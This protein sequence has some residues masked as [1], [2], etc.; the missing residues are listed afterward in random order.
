MGDNNVCTVA[1]KK[2]LRAIGHR[3]AGLPRNFNRNLPRSSVVVNEVQLFI[4]R[5]NQVGACSTCTRKL[6]KHVTRY[7]CSAIGHS[8]R[9]VSAR[10][11]GLGGV[12]TDSLFKQ[13]TK[14]GVG[15]LPPS[16]SLITVA[17]QSQS[18]IG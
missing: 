12:P 8:D 7:A 13:R 3:D 17:H 1:D 9:G 16:A 11:Y 6:Q 4:G 18:E 10:D 14:I 5:N 2:N 15:G